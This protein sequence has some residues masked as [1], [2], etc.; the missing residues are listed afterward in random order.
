LTTK[1]TAAE[2]KAKFADCV[3]AAEKGDS[4]VITRH[5]K[6]VAVIISPERLAHIERMEASEPKLGIASLI[7]GWEGSE[8]LVRILERIKR[9][10]AKQRPAPKL[11]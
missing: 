10:R 4:V 2:A 8:E 6:D 5:G 7:G 3:R 9:T 11:D 1:V